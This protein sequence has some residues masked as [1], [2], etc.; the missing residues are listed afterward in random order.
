MEVVCLTR[1]PLMPATSISP[2]SQRLRA[3]LTRH[4]LTPTTSISPISQRLRATMAQP[5]RKRGIVILLFHLPILLLLVVIMLL[6]HL[7]VLPAVL[8]GHLLDILLI[9]PALVGTLR[10]LMVLQ[11]LW[12][13]LPIASPLLPF[14]SPPLTPA[15]PRLSISP[16]RTHMST[17]TIWIQSKS[18]CQAPMDHS[19]PAQM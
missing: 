5:T 4:P 18:Q 9:A 12:I 15:R 7:P 8:L 16:T 11:W 1:H 2:I 3:P 14:I 13:L 6:L 10:V 19:M 17:K